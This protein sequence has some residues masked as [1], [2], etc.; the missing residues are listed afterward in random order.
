M[1]N[2]VFKIQNPI[3][4]EIFDWAEVIVMALLIT[5]ILKAYVVEFTQVSG[6][7][8]QPTLQDGNRLIINR[9]IYNLTEPKHGDIVV[10]DFSEEKS[11]IKR[12]IGLPGDVID[13][14]D[15][16]VY[17][18]DIKQEEGYI[19][20]KVQIYGD[21]NF[22]VTVTK[23]HYFV[24]G[25]NR[26]NSSDSRLKMVGDNGLVSKKVIRGPVVLRIWPFNEFGTIKYK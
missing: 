22:P 13:I 21:V 18:N 24:M 14:R 6:P 23:D 7:S 4:K 26:N 16:D 2:S 19:Q 5:F 12:I 3:L 11:F 8:M 10:F 25:D 9:F 20:E 15:G 17:I 1:I